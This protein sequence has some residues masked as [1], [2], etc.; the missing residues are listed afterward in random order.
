VRVK[1]SPGPYE[2]AG[3]PFHRQPIC[4]VLDTM[5]NAINVHEYHV[6]VTVSNSYGQGCLC[7][8]SQGVRNGCLRSLASPTVARCSS[9][10]QSSRYLICVCAIALCVRH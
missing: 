7:D 2:R 10:R 3:E 8:L 1:Q 4:E 9:G 5:G 6:S